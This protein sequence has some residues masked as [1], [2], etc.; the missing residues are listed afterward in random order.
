LSNGE[1]VTVSYGQYRAILATR[2]DQ[3]DREKA[4]VA[5]HETCKSSLNTYAALYN[6]VCQRDWF[7]ARARGYASTLEAALHGDN[8]PTSVVENLIETTR[9]GAEPLRRYHQLRRRT[10]GVPAY[11]V[12][13]FAIPLV[14]FDKKYDYEQMLDWIV[15]AAAPLGP[16]YQALMRK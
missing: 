5:L 7:Q 14:S 13:D 15:E 10:L 16:D 2:H 9:A 11:H 1:E 4:F 8:I 6:A 12:Y 3:S